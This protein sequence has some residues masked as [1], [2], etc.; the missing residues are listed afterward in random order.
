LFNSRS[1]VRFLETTGGS[2]FRAR[3]RCC[4]DRIRV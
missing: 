2:R 3:P 1:F 4:I